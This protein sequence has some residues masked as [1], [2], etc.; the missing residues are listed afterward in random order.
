MR[1]LLVVFQ[2]AGDVESI[3]GDSTVVVNDGASFG[4]Q[5]SELIR[6]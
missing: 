2:Q 3:G 4:Y 1:T 5:W 6:E